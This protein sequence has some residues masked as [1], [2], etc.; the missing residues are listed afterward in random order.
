MPRDTVRLTLKCFKEHFTKSMHNASALSTF[1]KNIDS[2]I[3]LG[4]SFLSNALPSNGSNNF[5]KVLIN[6]SRDY[7]EALERWKVFFGDSTYR[8][9]FKWEALFRK[10]SLF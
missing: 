8:S 3:L 7:Q 5:A 6:V 4:F 2:K 10:L 9:P 1:W